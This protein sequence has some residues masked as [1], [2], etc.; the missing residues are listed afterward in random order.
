VVLEHRWMLS[1]LSVGA[2]S[3]GMSGLVLHHLQK[4][5]LGETEIF[6]TEFVKQL[7]LIMAAIGAKS[8]EDIKKAP[9][10]FDGNLTNYMKQRHINF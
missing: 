4:Y 9:I 7:K 1:K 8:I 6:F 2:S 3:V 10:I 5:S